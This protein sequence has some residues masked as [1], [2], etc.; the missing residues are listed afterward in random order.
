LIGAVQAGNGIIVKYST[1][2]RPCRTEVWIDEEAPVGG[3]KDP[4]WSTIL[5]EPITEVRSLRFDFG[6]R[7]VKPGDKLELTWPMYAP[8]NAPV[9]TIAWN[10]FGYVAT[11]V[12]TGTKLLSSEPIKVGIEVK[13]ELNYTSKPKMISL[14]LT[15]LYLLPTMKTRI[16]V[17]IFSRS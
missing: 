17:I 14:C 6:D 15:D 1:E 8:I 16:L 10:S 4:A 13:C 11:R 5:P 7:V 3:C 12:D 9:G 2:E